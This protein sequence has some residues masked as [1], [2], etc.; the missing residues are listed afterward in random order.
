MKLI[1]H[2]LCLASLLALSAHSHGALTP[3]GSGD[4]IYDDQIDLT[5]RRCPEGMAWNGTTCSGSAQ[6][7]THVAALKQASAQA[8][9]SGKAWR[10]PNVKELESIVDIAQSNPAIDRT[11]FPATP[12]TA[13]WSSSP[14]AGDP[15]FA[16]S[17]NFNNGSVGSGVRS[18]GAAVRLVRAGQ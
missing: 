9:S 5:W 6:T 3:T 7:F 15:A 16:R 17:V 8:A 12:S 14:F 11:A 1:F 4:E 10:L 2:T 18:N 13:F